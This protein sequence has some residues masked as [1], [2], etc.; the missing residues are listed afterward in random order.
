LAVS[1]TAKKSCPELDPHTKPN[2][3]D[4]SGFFG[5][6]KSTGYRTQTML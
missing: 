6:S 4:I 5:R 1:H 3:V 2:S